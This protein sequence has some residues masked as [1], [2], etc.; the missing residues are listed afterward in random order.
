MSPSI[1]E[2]L[3]AIGLEGRIAGVTEFCQYP[4]KAKTLPKVGGVLN[5]NAEQIIALRSDLLIYHYD[6]YKI[7]RLAKQLGIPALEVSFDDLEHIFQSI[8]K[9]GA[10]TRNISK[11]NRLVNHLQTEI[12]TFQNRLKVL[13]PRS[14]LLVLGDSQNYMRDLYAV[15]Q[16]TFLD[17]LLTL[18][19]GNNIVQDS[20]TLYPKVSREFIIH[21]SPE[22]ILVAGP[23]AKLSEKEFNKHMEEWRKFSTVR[24]IKNHEIH[25]IGADYILIP[26]PRL[27]HI[28]DRFSR[29]LHPQ[30]FRGLSESLLELNSGETP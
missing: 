18:A 21:R 25:Y 5:P 23:K 1:T 19:G 26:G 15:G 11:A 2:I 13:P 8:L 27:V 3:F 14:T 9:I 16:G 22:V 28:I 30:A 20:P 24:A 12:S 29:A 17:E 6:S 7:A 4:E 10:V